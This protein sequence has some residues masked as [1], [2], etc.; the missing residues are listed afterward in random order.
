MCK[1]VDLESVYMSLTSSIL[2]PPLSRKFYSHSEVR[3]IFLDPPYTYYVNREN[4]GTENIQNAESDCKTNYIFS[5]CRKMSVL[6]MN[7][8]KNYLKTKK[9]KIDQKQIHFRFGQEVLETHE[10]NFKTNRIS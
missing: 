3:V 8:L 10:N 4:F 6:H 2:F 7:I 1:Y 5:I 9:S